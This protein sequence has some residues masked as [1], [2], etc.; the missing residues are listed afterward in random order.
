MR[1]AFLSDIHGNLPALEAVLDDI[2]RSGA[3][4]IIC[5]GDIANIGPHPGE[6]LDLV[7]DACDVVLQGNH[8]L[9]LLG[10]ITDVDWQTCPTWASMRW[11]RSR[12][13]PDQFDYMDS[14]PLRWDLPVAG[15]PA[16]CVHASPLTQ[17]RGFLAHH[18]DEQVA[19]RMDGVDGVTL[20]CAHTHIA[21][22]RRWSAS[23]IVNVGSVGMPLDGTPAAKYV[24]A[25]AT[26][27][28]WQFQFRR[29]R[30]DLARLMD[31]FEDSGLQAAGRGVTAVF[32]YQ[33]LT[34]KPTVGPYLDGLYRLAQERGVRMADVYD[35]YP[36]PAEV[37]GWVT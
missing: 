15:A 18:D 1:I 34:G 30:Y 33:M 6:C 29:V 28:G 36:V 35:D 10:R 24:L 4:Q 12:L 22:L 21:L 37:A 9:Y 7:A 3:D 14:L 8:E 27:A 17:Y 16:L 25:M 5:L 26:T 20:F 11:A 31:A 23:W 13:R 2:Q 19:E 32:R